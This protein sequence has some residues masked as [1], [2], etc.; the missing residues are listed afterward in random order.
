MTG[1]MTESVVLYKI[2]RFLLKKFPESP[3][4][5]RDFT[6]TSHQGQ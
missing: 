5:K 1:R 6:H 3:L 2:F 4:V